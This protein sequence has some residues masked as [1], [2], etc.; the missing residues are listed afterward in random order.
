MNNNDLP[1]LNYYYEHYAK[2]IVMNSY[3]LPPLK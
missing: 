3:D 2:G 1:L